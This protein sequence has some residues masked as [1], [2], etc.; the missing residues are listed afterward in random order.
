M[1]SPVYA[2]RRHPGAWRTE[3]AENRR[4]GYTT[5][6]ARFVGVTCSADAG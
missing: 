2:G 1:K 6:G 3:P 4:G 5:Q